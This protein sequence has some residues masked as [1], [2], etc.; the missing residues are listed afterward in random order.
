[1]KD[2]SKAWQVSAILCLA[3]ALV[4][5]FNLVEL[6]VRFKYGIA[7]YA[8]IIATPAVIVSFFLVQLAAAISLYRKSWTSMHSACLLVWLINM[9]I[10]FVLIWRTVPEKTV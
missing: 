3:C 4:V 1:M 2:S 7:L 5:P 8:Y 10:L 9:S 6:Y